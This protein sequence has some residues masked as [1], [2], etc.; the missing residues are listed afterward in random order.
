M[1]YIRWGSKPGKENK[2]GRRPYF[3]AIDME[4]I[5]HISLPLKPSKEKAAA[6]DFRGQY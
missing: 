2:T 5:F 3:A 6:E 4:F 1:P